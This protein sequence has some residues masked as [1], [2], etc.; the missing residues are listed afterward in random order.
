MTHL[1][2][3][4]DYMPPY[5][6][7]KIQWHPSNLSV[8]PDEVVGMHVVRDNRGYATHCYQSDGKVWIFPR[9]LQEFFTTSDPRIFFVD[10]I[11]RELECILK[12][13]GQEACTT[14]LQGTS[15][16][17]A[18]VAISY[19]GG[20]S[21]RLA[22][23]RSLRRIW[24]L[25]PFYPRYMIPEED[26][27]YG[28]QARGERLVKVMLNSGLPLSLH[29]CGSILSSLADLP[30]NSSPDKATKMAYNCY[31]GGWIESMKL[32]FFDEAY[33]YDLT[34]AYPT[35]AAKLLSCSPRHG[36]WYEIDNYVQEAAYGFAYCRVS[37]DIS[38]P[39]SPIMVRIQSFMTPDGV[40]PVRIIRNPIGSWEGW[41]TKDEIEYI[42]RNWLGEV[43]VLKGVWFIPTQ[44]YQPFL[45]LVK[46]LNRMRQSMK[47]QGDKLAGYLS[48]IISAALQGKFIQSSIVNGKRV[49]GTAFNPVYAST[50]TARVR[51]RVAET[52]LESYEHV[53]G[54]VVDGIITDAPLPVSNRW[55]LEYKGKCVIA[56]HG[57]Y[58][59][60]G[61]PTAAPLMQVLLANEQRHS[62]P[63][64]GVRYISLGEA[65]GSNFF[66]AAGRL[67]PERYAY[68]HKVGRRSWIKLPN[69]C[70][71]LLEKQYE[72]YPLFVGETAS[73]LADTEVHDERED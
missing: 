5:E 69:T 64:G 17:I 38:L 15:V 58:D 33:D 12:Y 1:I 56:N 2:N 66:E 19:H 59:I 27:C 57:D 48:K 32:G 68:V 49:V 54:V 37:I 8:R 36:S 10:G 52:A 65:I 42:H 47:G 63:I 9:D 60:A 18:G 43:E 40:T 72:S 14:L 31:H 50:I 53:L 30:F 70:G 23:D 3:E 45:P 46:E 13:L 29:S 39:F 73:G 34:S 55:K 25:K 7:L 16:G 51:L 22:G 62:Y 71:D 4:R 67:R 61:R 28:V 26:D 11:D 35:E 24:T 21:T 41:L 44:Y 6:D 20:L